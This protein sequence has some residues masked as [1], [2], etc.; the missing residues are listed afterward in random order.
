MS[1]GDV[2]VVLAANQQV[3]GAKMMRVHGQNI[4]PIRFVAA[5][6]CRRYVLLPICDPFWADMFCPDTFYPDTFC[7]CT[8][9]ATCQQVGCK[10]IT[11]WMS[12]GGVL[13]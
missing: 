6:F 10:S 3:Q 9:L 13:D 8:S 4:S 12:A 11:G 1:A 7:P 5:T 2:R